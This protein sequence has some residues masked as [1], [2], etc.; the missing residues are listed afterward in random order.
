VIPAFIVDDEVAEVIASKT[1]SMATWG[2]LSARTGVGRLY[3]HRFVWSLLRG[4]PPEIIDHIN[5]NPLD[6]RIAN[7][8]PATR[9]LNSL[10]RERRSSRAYPL[11]RGVCRDRTS[12]SR[13]YRAIARI[14]GRTRS[15]GFYATPEEASAVY[16]AW[17][18][19]EIEAEA[20]RV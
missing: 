19:S 13:P 5:R 9:R 1:W 15:L 18:A 2:Y 8:R 17:L 4:D 11:P 12:V 20:R 10:N 16:Q 3:L 6:N 14:A 7:L